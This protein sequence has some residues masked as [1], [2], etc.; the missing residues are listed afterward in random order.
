MAV[1]YL[2]LVWC[3]SILGVRGSSTLQTV[4]G[5]KDCN[6]KPVGYALN[7]VENVPRLFIYIIKITILTLYIIYIFTLL[8]YYNN[9]YWSLVK[10]WMFALISKNYFDYS[11]RVKSKQK[12]ILT[13]LVNF[14]WTTFAKKG[15]IWPLHYYNYCRQ[16]AQNQGWKQHKHKCLVTEAPCSSHC[17]VFFYWYCTLLK[18]TTN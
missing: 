18:L 14:H 4:T 7:S 2:W 1:S 3:I 9:Y 5:M 10:I 16:P 17:P 8:F 15:Q 6:N 11:A 13:A 12:V